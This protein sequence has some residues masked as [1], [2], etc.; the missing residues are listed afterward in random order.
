MRCLFNLESLLKLIDPEPVLIDHQACLAARHKRA[1]C[2]ACVDLCP[3]GALTVSEG[4][5]QVDS[6]TCT[7]CGL[8]VGVCPTSAVSIRGVDEA[9]IL[10]AAT[11][12]CSKV[13][14][15]GAQVPCLGYLSTDHLIG[16]G[17]Q[18]ESF[19]LVSG[20]CEAC[21][22]R[23]GGALAGRAVD[24]AQ[25]ALTAMGSS[26]T[27]RLVRQSDLET[28]Q[29]ASG[30][31]L[32][33]RDLFSLWRAESIQVAKQFVPERTINFA[34]L[35]SKVP[36]RRVR[37]LR[38]VSPE[39]VATD[40][41]MPAGPWKGRVVSDACTGCPICVSFCPTGALT[42]VEENGEWVLSH[43][44]AACVGCNTCV[45]LCPTRAIGEEPIPVEAMVAGEVRELARRAEKRCATCR[46]E[47][48]GRPT[49]THCPQCRSV[50][51]MLKS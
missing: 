20:D 43:Q 44:P 7:R 38:Q 5:V 19:E 47:F 25:E 4:K 32:S 10:N 11:V 31:S 35:P 6:G 24:A 21:P 41:V 17:L 49:D 16:M 36:A 3:V 15:S 27:L 39:G 48:R 9:A 50:L 37:W 34:K 8:C 18:R 28:D 51:K 23:E 30:R 45:Q 42:K 46:R 26:H 12:S 22:W 40:A 29:T 13:A 14:G 1:A 2:R 33:R